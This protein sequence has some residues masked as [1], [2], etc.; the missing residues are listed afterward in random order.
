MRRWIVRGGLAALLALAVA[1]AVTRPEVADPAPLNALSGDPA[2][3][4]TVFW[5]GGCVSCHAPPGTEGPDRLVLAGGLRLAT[6]FGTFVAPNIS[7]DPD[8]GIGAWS[9]ADLYNAMHHGTSP[10]GEHYY[11]AFPYTSYVHATAQDVADLMAFLRT[12]PPS[13]RANLPHELGFPFNQRLLMGPWKMLNPAPAWVVTGDL[14]AAEERGRYLVEGIGHCAE[15]H[16][17]RN[18]LGIRDT[19]RWLAGGPNP[20]GR[21]TIPNITPAHLDWS[22]ADIAEYLTSGFTPE[23][24]SAGGQM[25]DV[26]TNIARLPDADRQAIAAYLA[27]VAPVP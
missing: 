23:Y 22:A 3:G 16:T 17:P 7:P 8:H 18:V 4:E 6:P 9:T 25:A 21:G 11:P 24:D 26:V 10:R 27:R 1:W 20:E 5:A 2:K 12:L 19:G 13:N 14:T 15:C